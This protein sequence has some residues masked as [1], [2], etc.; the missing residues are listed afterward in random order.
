M[1][2]RNVL[3]TTGVNTSSFL[4]WKKRVNHTARNL[5]GLSLTE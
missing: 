4:S 1:S 2:E 3:E 5:T